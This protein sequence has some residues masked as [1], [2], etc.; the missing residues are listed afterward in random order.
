MENFSAR[1]TYL[2]APFDEK[3]AF[4]ADP[5]FLEA[6]FESA[7]NLAE[8]LTDLERALFTDEPDTSGFDDPPPESLDNKMESQVLNNDVMFSSSIPEID[9]LL[10]FVPG[11]GFD[12]EDAVEGDEIHYEDSDPEDAAI[13]EEKEEKNPPRKKTSKS[14]SNGKK[15]LYSSG[16]FSDPGMER[17]RLNA[18][19]AK[20]NRDRKKREQE[21]MKKELSRLRSENSLLKRKSL[22]MIERA[23]NAESELRRLQD[24]LRH[25]NLSDLLKLKGKGGSDRFN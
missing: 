1:D 15:K 23:S 18:L 7:W 8:P 19:N 3:I 5:G 11:Q 16:P 20:K 2:S 17:C 12:P 4:F 9:E 14:F 25:N 21:K 13:W 10:E 6:D 22:K 24:V